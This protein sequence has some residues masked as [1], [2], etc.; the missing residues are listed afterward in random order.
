MACPSAGCDWA[1]WNFVVE[2]LNSVE[3]SASTTQP[4]ALG[5]GTVWRSPSPVGIFIFIQ[6][7][8]CPWGRRLSSV[9]GSTDSKSPRPAPGVS[10]RQPEQF[11]TQGSQRLGRRGTMEGL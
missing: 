11:C 5:P 10:T 9:L 3:I 7:V 1:I 6:A 2:P 4:I 8:I